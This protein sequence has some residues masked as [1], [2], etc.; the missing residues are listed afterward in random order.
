MRVL[1]LTYGTR[2][3]VQ[4]F[5]ALGKGLRARGHEVMIATSDRFE[6]FVTGH[7]LQYGYI[8]DEFLAI[9]DTDQGRDMLENTSNIFQV[10]GRF[11]SM[12]RKVGP[13]QK[14]LLEDSWTATRDFGPDL[15][16]FHPKVYGGPHFAEKLGVPVMMGLLIPMMVPT[17]EQPN[18]GFP[19]L[20][21]G[22]RYNRFTYQVVDILTGI[23][24]GKYVRAWRREHGLAKIR[25]FDSLHTADGSP[26]PTLHAISPHVAPPPGDW[27]DTAHMTGYWFLETEESWAPPPGLE[28]FLAAGDPPVYAGFGSMAGRDPERLGRIVVDALQ[29]AGK[30]GLLVRGWGGLDARDLPDTILQIDYAPHDWLLSQM[31]AVIH[32]GGAGTTAGGLKA[33]KP[34]IITPFFGDQPYWGERIH[35]LGA[36]PAPIPHRK[37]SADRLAAAITE[38]TGDTAMQRRA[39]EIGRL[40]REERGI[41]NAIRL[42]EAAKG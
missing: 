22:G 26:I 13:M 29:K 34:T 6:E 5:V 33:G 3:D 25:G 19:A 40:L 36:G 42:I 27:P 35:A 10:L 23:A 12:I 38:A 14:A 9:L 32:H 24:A 1:L 31:A 20:P 4:P 30:R 16:L 8:S 2:G 41:D 28:A 37:L 21:L 18:M 11:F 7:G 15:I 17:A 39:E